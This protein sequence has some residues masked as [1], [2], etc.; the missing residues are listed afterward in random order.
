MQANGRWDLTQ[1]L[2]GYLTVRPS[3]LHLSVET[4]APMKD[5]NDIDICASVLKKLDLKTKGAI[6]NRRAIAILSLPF[7]AFA[8]SYKLNVTF[9]FTN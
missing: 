8:V 2:K 6:R 9:T 3:F 4:Y 5:F 1:R 7:W